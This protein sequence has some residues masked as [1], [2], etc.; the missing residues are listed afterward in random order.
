[1]VIQMTEQK[2]IEYKPRSTEQLLKAY[3]DSMRSLQTYSFFT[4]PRMG[5]AIIKRQNGITAKPTKEA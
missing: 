4:V 5:M 3:F 2:L 1:M